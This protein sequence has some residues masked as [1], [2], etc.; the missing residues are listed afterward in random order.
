MTPALEHARSLMQ[1]IDLPLQELTPVAYPGLITGLDPTGTDALAADIRAR[2]PHLVQPRMIAGRDGEALS[3]NDLFIRTPGTSV[4]TVQPV[5]FAW[6]CLVPVFGTSRLLDKP[7]VAVTPGSNAYLRV[8]WTRLSTVV[9]S[10]DATLFLHSDPD[11]EAQNIAPESITDSPTVT[12][13]HK[14]GSFDAAGNWQT[15][16]PA[17]ATAPIL[18]PPYPFDS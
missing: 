3:L 10:T 1:A 8:R 17:F 6:P 5:L 9:T 2:Y 16:G 13:T 15:F 12:W 11:L 14:I 7:Q 18:L 4:F